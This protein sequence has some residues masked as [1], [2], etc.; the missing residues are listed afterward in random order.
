MT[1][2]LACT[3]LYL[4]R[5]GGYE[6]DLIAKS[7]GGEDGESKGKGVSSDVQLRST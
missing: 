2:T 4:L 5:S 6:E 3:F 7:A 1:L